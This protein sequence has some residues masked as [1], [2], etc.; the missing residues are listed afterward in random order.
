MLNK[1]LKQI[2]SMSMINIQ[3]KYNV[4]IGNSVLSTRLIFALVFL[5]LVSSNEHIGNTYNKA[6]LL[7]PTKRVTKPSC[8]EHFNGCM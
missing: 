7:H 6:T 2:H 5:V 4:P 3:N 8:I 1:I